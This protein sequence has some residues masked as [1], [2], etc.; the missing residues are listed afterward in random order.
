[1]NVGSGGGAAA[2]TSGGAAAGGDA[3]AEAAKEEEKEE[4][5]SHTT[6]IER[7]TQFTNNVHSKGRV[8]RGH[9]FRSFR[10]SSLRNHSSVLCI[11]DAWMVTVLPHLE[12]C[13]AGRATFNRLSTL[14]KGNLN[15]ICN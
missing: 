6:T 10:L 14:M 3:P 2:P 1:L 9:G 15:I 5:S 11:F 4:G 12:Q 13:L 7:A 8:R